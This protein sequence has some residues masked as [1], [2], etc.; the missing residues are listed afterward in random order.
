MLNS[1]FV[2][3]FATRPW[4]FGQRQLWYFDFDSG[5]VRQK[6][7]ETLFARTADNSKDVEARLNQVIETPLSAEVARWLRGQTAAADLP[8]PLCRAVALLLLAQPIRSSTDPARNE[9]LEELVMRDDAELDQLALA[10]EQRY[11][12][13]R[14]SVRAD[15]AVLYPSAGWFPLPAQDGEGHWRTCP[16]IPVGLKHVIV[17]VPRTFPFDAVADVWRANGSGLV[18]NYSVGHNSA[19]VVLPP[20]HRAEYQDEEIAKLLRDLRA[21]VANGLAL[22]RQAND[23]LAQIDAFI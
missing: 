7:S 10:A 5:E 19:R 22:M 16:A 17:A 4:E 12:M 3:R 21:N 2:S 23:L 11:Q 8:W 20:S 13:G 9:R 18:A 6:S 1:H 14:I 15:A